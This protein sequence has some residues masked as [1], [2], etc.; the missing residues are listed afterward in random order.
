MKFSKPIVAITIGDP[1]GIGPEITVKAL[2]KLKR[3]TS[4][5][6]LVVGE[7]DILKKYGWSDDLASLIEPY[8]RKFPSSKI[9]KPSALGGKLSFEFVHKAVKLVY[10]NQAQIIVTAPIAKESW[11]KAGLDYSGHTELLTKLISIPSPPVGRVGAG[12]IPA[13]MGRACPEQSRRSEGVKNYTP[14]MLMVAVLPNNRQLRALLVTRH[15]P[16]KDVSA[17]LSISKIFQSIKLADRSLKKYFR[18]SQPRI[19]VCSLNPH[20]GEAG[21]FGKEEKEIIFPAVKKL[22]NAGIDVFGP[23]PSDQVFWQANQGKYDLVAAMYHDQAMIPLKLLAYHSVVNVTLGLPFIR[24]SPGHGT[25]FDIAGKNI[26]NP[27]AMV[28]AIKLAVK[29]YQLA[30]PYRLNV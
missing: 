7:K 24:T 4:F 10:R 21:I 18:V 17:N 6:P 25:A 11:Y 20:S 14:E 13:R 19:G 3:W 30:N 9:G 26:A 15:L 5:T 12:F 23:Y 27:Q 2:K 29:M 28:E 16:L 1:A 8:S 22:R